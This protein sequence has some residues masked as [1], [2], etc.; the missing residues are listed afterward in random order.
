MPL[1]G[2]D[3]HVQFVRANADPNPSNH[4]NFLNAIRSET[5]ALASAGIRWTAT[6]RRERPSEVAA[7]AKADLLVL[8][9]HRRRP[10]FHFGST[11]EHVL[12]NAHVP[13]LIGGEEPR[14]ALATVLCAVD[15]GGPEASAVLAEA[16]RLGGAMACRIEVV[17]V[18]TEA[19]LDA[20]P[21]AWLHSLSERVS[22]VP[23]LGSAGLQ[24]IAASDP[25]AGLQAVGGRA[26]L[27][28]LGRSPRAGMA[29]W[30]G[31]DTTGKLGRFARHP[32]LLVPSEGA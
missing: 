16:A 27:V 9:P 3:S 26:D 25:A 1:L 20:E 21:A 23:G 19:E 7:G 10:N 28:V 4:A 6:L 13:V 2:A 18:V 24:V 15:L 8:G 30:W 22:S 12:A 32:L 11:A 17:S 31:G 29:R 5:A 14:G